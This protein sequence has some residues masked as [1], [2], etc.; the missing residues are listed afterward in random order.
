VPYNTDMKLIM[1]LKKKRSES[2]P[3]SWNRMK[4]PH[5]GRNLVPDRTWTS[6]GESVLSLIEFC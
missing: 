5:M 3:K 4:V 2:F 1:T 6:D